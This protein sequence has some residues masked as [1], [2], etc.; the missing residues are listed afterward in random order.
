MDF[1]I[2]GLTFL[3]DAELVA[4][5]VTGCLALAN[6]KSTGILEVDDPWAD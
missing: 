4:D 5:D 2:P 1:D 6:D 3:D